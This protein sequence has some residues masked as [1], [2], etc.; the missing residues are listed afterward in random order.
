MAI[1]EQVESWFK[2]LSGGLLDAF[3][4]LGS[5]RKVLEF[6]RPFFALFP[7]SVARHLKKSSLDE[8][9]TF[10]NA[11]EQLDLVGECQSRNAPVR[12]DEIVGQV[13]EG[14]EVHL[15][16]SAAPL[17]VEGE[18]EGFVFVSL[19]NVTDEAQVQ[20]KY[21]T[22]LAEEA[23]QRELLQQEIRQAQSEL[24]RV[25]DALNEVEDELRAYQKGLLL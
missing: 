23:R 8:V 18:A 25:K 5:D 16:A 14:D 20:T 3:V 19:R 2:Q 21:K 10:L 15:I 24:V 9:M 22:M 6:N 12:Y 4:L 13:K 11:G 1:P 17:Q 7:R